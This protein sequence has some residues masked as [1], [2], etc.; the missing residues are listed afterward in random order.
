MHVGL[1]T[2]RSRVDPVS[3]SFARHGIDHLSASSINQ[4]TGSP[5]LWVL[6][7]LLGQR[8]HAGA[9]A[10]RGTA[11][12]AGIAAGLLD[13]SKSFEDCQRS[14]WPGLTR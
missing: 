10:H 5:S 14:H 6:E 8:G 4:Y 2:Y 12:E 7:R 13:M 9:P 3:N 11:A 1:P